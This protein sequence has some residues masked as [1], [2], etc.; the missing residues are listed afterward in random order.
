MHYNDNCVNLNYD[1]TE[2]GK[3]SSVIKY[4]Q[5]ISAV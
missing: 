2:I 1:D 3:G 5:E 4:T